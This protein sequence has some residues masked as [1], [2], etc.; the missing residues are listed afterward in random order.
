MLVALQSR[1]P[2]ASEAEC[3]DPPGPRQR[4]CHDL[5]GSTPSSPAAGEM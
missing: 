4:A 2:V 1:P 5:P 3:L